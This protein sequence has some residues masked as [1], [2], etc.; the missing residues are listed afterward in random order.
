MLPMP[1]SVI[2]PG[3]AGRATVV[4]LPMP[5]TLAGQRGGSPW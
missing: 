4:T 3:P 1:G 2:P 5:G